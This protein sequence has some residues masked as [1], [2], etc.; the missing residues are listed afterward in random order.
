MP[1]RASTESAAGSRKRASAPPPPED[2]SE[3][4]DAGIPDTQQAPT[5]GPP[6]VDIGERDRLAGEIGR[7][8]LFQEHTKR[9]VTRADI[10]KAV[11]PD[12]KGRQG[13]KALD[14]AMEHANVML[15]ETFGLQMTKLPDVHALEKLRNQ[16][17]KEKDLPT[18]T[19][20][21]SQADDPLASSE[22]KYVLSSILPKPVTVK[23]FSADH[24]KYLGLVMVVLEIIRFS[25]HRVLQTKLF[26]Y[27]AK[28]G[29]KPGSE[30]PFTA[31]HDTVTKRMVRDGYIVLSKQSG[32]PTDPEFIEGP[33]AKLE[34]QDNDWLAFEQDIG[35][36]QG[37]GSQPT[38]TQ[39]V[40]QTQL[41]EAQPQVAS[42][43]GA[44]A[45][46]AVGWHAEARHVGALD[47]LCF[48]APGEWR[49]IAEATVVGMGIALSIGS[50][51]FKGTRA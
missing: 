49:Q 48:V 15:K 26:D 3:E 13:G 40:S 50:R 36:S 8:L 47:T 20:R 31:L 46:R 1:K 42:G 38:Q 12:A 45:D 14:Y 11:M 27:L 23:E 22:H 6:P 16:S 21:G 39:R 37:G 17:N 33:R 4:E 19:Q 44:A 35:L 9:G 18:Q 28:L 30:A 43:S 51:G 24:K 10:K 5:Q 7:Y 32:A 25:D 2:V 29:L 34:V 41:Q